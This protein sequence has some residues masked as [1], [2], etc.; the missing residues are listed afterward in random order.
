MKLISAQIAVDLCKAEALKQY[1]K[2]RADITLGMD[3]G[4]VDPIT[5]QNWLDINEARMAGAR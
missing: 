2:L 3:T 1:K 5:G 4:R